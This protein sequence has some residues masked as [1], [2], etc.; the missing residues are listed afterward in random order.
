MAELAQLQ[1]R[2]PHPDQARVA[3]R[4]SS[5]SSTDGVVQMTV[6]EVVYCDGAIWW[7]ISLA[8]DPDGGELGTH[9]DIGGEELL[10]VLETGTD[11]ILGLGIDYAAKFSQLARLRQL[12]LIVR[13]WKQNDPDTARSRA[14]GRIDHLMIWQGKAYGRGGEPAYVQRPIHGSI[15]Y[16]NGMVNIGADRS[17]EPRDQGLALDVGRFEFGQ[18]AFMRGTFQR[19]DE[20]DAAVANRSTANKPS[21]APE[22]IEVLMP[23]FLKMN[24]GQ[25]R[26]DAI[27]RA[28]SRAL[29]NRDEPIWADLRDLFAETT[30]KDCSSP[31]TSR[32][33]FDAMLS[34]AGVASN[35][36]ILPA[37]LDEAYRCFLDFEKS[38]DL[39]ELGPLIAIEDDEALAAM[40]AQIA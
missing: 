25:I 30:A 13:E 19:A 9:Q 20:Y 2:A 18:P 14:Q 12:G 6:R 32:A 1:I 26:L 38:P 29:L 21:Q 22:R 17:V 11:D 10:R 37:E 15:Q 27:Y 34:F 39:S 8:F 31:T 4:L 5:V 7:P 16:A 24:R 3:F 33:R 28:T 36:R 23:D 35:Q 40:G